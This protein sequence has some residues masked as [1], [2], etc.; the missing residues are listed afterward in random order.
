MT[1]KKIAALVLAAVMLVGASIAGTLAWLT[2]S[3]N[4]VTNTFSPS[5]IGIELKESPLKTGST[6]TLD[7][8]AADDNNWSSRVTSEDGYQMVP[9]FDL[10]KDPAVMV[11]A[12][13]EACFVFVKIEAENNGT[14]A[15]PYLTYEIGSDWEAVAGET[16]VYVYKDVI[17]KSDDNQYLK[18]ILA[19]DKVT[20][21]SAL[22]ADDMAAA[23]GNEP[24]LVLPAYATQANKHNTDKFTV[25]EAWANASAQ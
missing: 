7:K 19:D 9:G 12:E 10:Q 13:S 21:N 2:A 11:K 17:E 15:K 6:N 23:D 24:E 1:T 20:V 8:K 4:E 14:A 25:A 18:E 22:T 5:S 3:T 16:G